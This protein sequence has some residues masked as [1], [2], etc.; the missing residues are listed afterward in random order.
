MCFVCVAGVVHVCFAYH[1]CIR[2]STFLMNLLCACVFF[3]VYFHYFYVN[4]LC[5]FLHFLCVCCACVSCTACVSRLC[6]F[7]MRF[8]ELVVCVSAFVVCFLCMC[9]VGFARHVFCIFIILFLELAVCFSACVAC[10]LCV[11]C[12]WFVCRFCVYFRTCSMNLVCLF[13]SFVS[14]VLHIIFV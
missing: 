4:P 13:S 12:A 11:F 9:R 6:V 14:C 10:D 8:Y 3:G 1:S 7:P 5:V 2:F